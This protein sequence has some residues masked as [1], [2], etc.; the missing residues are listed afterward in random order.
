MIDGWNE[1]TETGGACLYVESGQRG[2]VYSVDISV[3]KSFRV[4]GGR[5]GRATEGNNKCCFAANLD[6]SL[7]DGSHY[8][9]LQWQGYMKEK[10]ALDSRQQFPP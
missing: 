2:C 10:F 1:C 4:R 6:K 8:I 7:H 3:A 9:F 5:R